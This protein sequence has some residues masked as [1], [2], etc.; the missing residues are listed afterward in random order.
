MYLGCDW[1]EFRVLRRIAGV[2]EVA[3]RMDCCQMRLVD[4][5]L[6]VLGSVYLFI[7]N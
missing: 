4:G 2:V 1:V 6:F 3:P 7:L 5:I